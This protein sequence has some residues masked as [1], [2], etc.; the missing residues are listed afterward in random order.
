MEIKDFLLIK[1]PVAG[2]GKARSQAWID[3]LIEKIENKGLS[4]DLVETQQH[5]HASELAQEMA[6][7]YK[8]VVAM[9][10]DGTVHEVAQGLIKADGGA[11]G[12]LPIGNGNDY[13]RSFNSK[14]SPKMAIEKLLA[15][16]TMDIDVGVDSEGRYIL[17][18][19]S[20]GLDSYTNALQKK[21][22]RY[23]PRTLGYFVALV[24]SI[25]A[26]KKQK[27][28]VTLD[29]QSFESS[30]V[31]FCFG[32]GQSYGGGFR[33]M[34]WAKLDDG[35]FHVVNIIDLSWPILY[36]VAPS[37]LFGLHTKFTKYVKVYKAK[38][39]HVEADTFTLN[40][41][42]EVFETDSISARILENKLKMIV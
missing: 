3:R 28:K 21:L 7:K 12:I 18:I 19:A 4:Y 6:G 1:N 31:L 40:I 32:N 20:L 42:G 16:K 17:N 30:N 38:E 26:Y 2:S 5:G 10:G 33:I 37:I 41:D 39:I 35:Y 8:T 9:G 15:G 22:K 36:L 13:Y 34:P 14:V 23:F 25:F 24:Y 29:G 27:I 11:L